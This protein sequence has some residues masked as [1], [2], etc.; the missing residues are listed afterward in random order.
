[1]KFQPFFF[2]RGIL[3]FLHMKYTFAYLLQ[4]NERTTISSTFLSMKF[5]SSISI[6]SS[7]YRVM[8][9][10]P[11]CPFHPEK[12]KHAIPPFLVPL[13]LHMNNIFTHLQ[14]KIWRTTIVPPYLTWSTYCSFYVFLCSSW[15]RVMSLF[16]ICL[17][18]LD[19][20]KHV[21]LPLFGWKIPL[22]SAHEENIQLFFFYN[23]KIYCN[24]KR[25]QL[26]KIKDEQ[27]TTTGKRKKEIKIY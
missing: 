20:L 14:L 18:N 25:D 8:C 2:G 10:F 23:S 15:S 4:L 19:K 6:I 17:L 1:M 13:P 21:I 7:W 9:S 24:E 26:Q 3:H 5:V 16:P 11:I 12:F 27:K 22:P